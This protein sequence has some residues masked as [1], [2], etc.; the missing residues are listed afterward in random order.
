MKDWRELLN[1]HDV[2]DLPATAVCSP[3]LAS[4]PPSPVRAQSPP[5]LAGGTVS[6]S[7][8]ASGFSAELLAAGLAPRSA[9]RRALVRRTFAVV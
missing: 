7:A 6:F 4:T 8:A 2:P 9:I 1:V 5:P 3:V